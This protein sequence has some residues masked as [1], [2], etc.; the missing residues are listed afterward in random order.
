MS[1]STL[2]TTVS[3]GHVD[4]ILTVYSVS[5][6]YY[7]YKRT[8][9]ALPPFKHFQF[10]DVNSHQSE[11]IAKLQ[12]F[13]MSGRR[14]SRTS[15]F[16]ESDIND[17]LLMLQALLPQQNQTSNSRVWQLTMAVNANF[18]EW[19]FLHSLNKIL[20]MFCCRYQWAWCRS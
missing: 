17:L 15:K 5:T 16:R 6:V 11:H 2:K 3:V 19:K 18:K 7:Q 20:S 14:K 9:F 4:L 13:S 8:V 10:L 1:L 12:T